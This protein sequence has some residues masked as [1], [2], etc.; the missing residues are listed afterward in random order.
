MQSQLILRWVV[1]SPIII[2]L[3]FCLFFFCWLIR[4][5]L[6]IISRPRIHY[7]WIY[8]ESRFVRGNWNIHYFFTFFLP[9]NLFAHIHYGMELCNNFHSIDE[10]NVI[11][12]FACIS[13]D[14]IDY[15]VWSSM[16]LWHKDGCSLWIHSL[17]SS[18]L[19]VLLLF[20]CDSGC[21]NQHRTIWFVDDREWE[22][23]THWKKTTIAYE[24]NTFVYGK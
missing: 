24:N 1:I 19:F 6:W 17:H 7:I 20:L 5:D 13:I 11:A 10:C 9:M 8:A 21:T 15:S 4:L 12:R 22:D 18:V 2:S 14:I 23:K 16:T 3:F